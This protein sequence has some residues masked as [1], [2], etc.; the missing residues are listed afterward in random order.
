MECPDPNSCP[1]PKSL[2]FISFH[3]DPP[4]RAPLRRTVVEE[5]GVGQPLRKDWILSLNC[6]VA[7]SKFNAR[8]EGSRSPF[9]EVADYPTSMS[10]STDDATAVRTSMSFPL[11]SF[12]RGDEERGWKFNPECQLSRRIGYRLGEEGGR[13]AQGSVKMTRRRHNVFAPSLFA[14]VDYVLHYNTTEIINVYDTCFKQRV[15]FLSE[16]E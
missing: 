9:P 16:I 8:S 13:V 14:V 15:Y 10:T 2:S 1:D 12:R 7:F 11:R 5:N 4:L 3:T 6:K